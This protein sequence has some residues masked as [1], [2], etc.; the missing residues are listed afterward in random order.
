MACDAEP[1][2]IEAVIRHL[3][4]SL[5]GEEDVDLA[6]YVVAY[7]ELS[8]MFHRL[9]RMFTFV[10]SD[11]RDKRDILK[12]L[13]QSDPEKYATV[14]SMAD[15]E[16]PEPAT[17][18]KDIGARTLLRLHRA[19]DFIVVFVEAV[20]LSQPDSNVGR[21]LADAYTKTLAHHHGFLVRKAVGLAT[22][23]VPSRSVLIQVIFGHGDEPPSDEL[24][25]REAK[26]FVASVKGVYDRVQAI[27][28]QKSLLELP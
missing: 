16:V 3:D 28:E 27:Y 11:V 5:V 2:D 23:F 1:F 10:E 20:H 15:Y 8:K 9:G 24:V 19:L 26:R 22:A 13:N 12:R 7:E 25:D 21:L 14:I 6:E 18:P 17:K 4:A